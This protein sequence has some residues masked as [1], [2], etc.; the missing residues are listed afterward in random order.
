MRPDKML[1]LYLKGWPFFLAHAAAYRR[2]CRDR[3]FA[4]RWSDLWY[5]SYQRFLPAGSVPGHY[6]LQDIWAAT[7]VRRAGCRRVVDV[8]SR[9]DGFVAHVLP[10]CRVTY[11]DIRAPRVQVPGLDFVQ[12]SITAL[13]LATGSVPLLSCL[14]VIEHIG[15]GR[16]GDPVDPDGYL[17]AA[18]E[19]GRVLQSGGRLLLGTPVGRERLCFDAHRVFDPQTLVAA[20]AGLRLEEFSL[21]DDSGIGV[22]D[23]ASFEQARRCTFGCGLFT[24]SKR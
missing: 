11:V 3:R 7:H 12:G 19:L 8:G 5:T 2:R 23:G 9:L 24:F 4:L 1:W 22:V 21:V 13:P 16:Y 14:H 17:S 20:L 10:F 6:F 18:R 15:L